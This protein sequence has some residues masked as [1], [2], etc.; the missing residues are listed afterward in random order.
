MSSLNPG[1]NQRI[2][3]NQLVRKSWKFLLILLFAVVGWAYFFTGTPPFGYRLTL[4]EAPVASIEFAMS[5]KLEITKSNLCAEV[6]HTLQKARNGG[7]V[8]PCPVIGNLTIHFADGTTNH[9]HLMPGHRLNRLDLVAKS[10][11]YSISM[12]ELFGTL[13]KVGLLTR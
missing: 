10:G 6:L 8:H 3:S 11:M 9:F 4:N 12:G 13:E 1:M 5:A 2:R 7:P